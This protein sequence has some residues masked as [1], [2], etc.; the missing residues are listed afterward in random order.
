MGYGNYVTINLKVT[1]VSKISA[2]LFKEVGLKS[3]IN[4]SF[5]K[6]DKN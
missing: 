6:N 3:V 4:E 2:L 5:I 1:Q